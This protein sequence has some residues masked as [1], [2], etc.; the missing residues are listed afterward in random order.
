[1]LN[2]QKNRLPEST[3][4]EVVLLLACMLWGASFPVMQMCIQQVG[5]YYYMLI[6]HVFAVIL[7]LPFLP[8]ILRREKAL[9]LLP[10]GAL[11][12]LLYFL[13]CLFQAWGFERIPAGRNAFITAL[14]VVVTPLLAPFF[15]AGKLK[16]N[17]AFG[18]VVVLSGMYLLL[19]PL[20]SEGN[21]WGDI[22]T[23]CGTI[24]FALHM[25]TLQLIMKKYNR[26]FLFAF[27]QTVF[28]ALFSFFPVVFFTNTA[29][30]VLTQTPL[31]I[32]LLFVFLGLLVVALILQLWLQPK[33]TPTRAAL[34]FN[35]QPAFAALM[36]Y[37]IMGEKMTS[38]ALIGA[39]I[40]LWGV[41][42][43]TV[44][45]AR[46]KQAHINASQRS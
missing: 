30:S 9:L 17:D 38:I 40:M 13:A 36:S 28:L 11:L 35:L 34:I 46:T 37:F 42:T 7:F 39:F 31:S 4:A 18:I 8:L 19:D 2:I 15:H 16:K 26:P 6:K 27:Y 10:F 3:F 22:L 25:Q 12:G 45:G 33:T 24:F 29:H 21:W 23:F 43:T 44:I 14:I 41:V 32:W 1:M 5:P 20:H